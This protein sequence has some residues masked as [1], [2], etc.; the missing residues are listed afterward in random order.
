MA[1]PR[2][3]LGRAEDPAIQALMRQ[4]DTQS[5]HTLAAWAIACARARYLPLFEVACPGDA[6]PRAALDAAQAA[7]SGACTLR[8]A[9]AA[10]P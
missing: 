3:M 9:E 6:R 5:A 1:K 8:E 10:A 7:Q 4:M 2:K